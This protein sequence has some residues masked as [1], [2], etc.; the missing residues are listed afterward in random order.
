MDDWKMKTHRTVRFLLLIFLLAAAF[1]I[2]TVF[3]LPLFRNPT[4]KK[5]PTKSSLNHPVKPTPVLW[6][7]PVSATVN[8]PTALPCG[9]LVTD[10]HGLIL[11]LTETGDIRWQASY[12]NHVWQA[13]SV[14]DNETICA[15]TRKGKLVLFETITGVIKWSVE[16]EVSCLHPP[17]VEMLNQQRVIIL[18]SQDDG[19]LVCVN[20]HDG[21]FRWRSPATSRSD[22]PPIRVGDFIAYGNCDAAV[23]LFS[24][25][26]G[27]LKGSIQLAEDEQ[28]A[29]GV[30]RLTDGRLIVGTRSGKLAMLD[31]LRMRCV[32]RVTVSDSE[33]F[34]TPV[35]IGTNRIFM[36]VSE[37]RMTFWK[38]EGD[39]L[40]ADTGV[41]LASQFD[42]TCVV[43]NIFWAI[44][45]HSVY[46]VRTTDP[47]H[48]IQ[49]ELGDNLHG[50]APSCFGKT[51][52]IAD[53][54]LV[55]VKG[56]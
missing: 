13:S 56:F 55:C 3:H 19:T 51:V 24:I 35:Q 7:I 11:S 27:C 52:V 18:L 53:G 46:G 26:N 4:E 25:T 31:T 2:Y 41:Q 40:I 33:A 45:Q 22:G 1:A 12:S 15:I 49:Y 48:R 37:G 36:P 6:C 28:V 10:T 9:W 17:L 42:E 21:S 5:I 39:R 16:T 20:A 43:D 32:S 47:S 23:H 50:I 44:A 8:K 14:V 34:A 54:E 38:I 29:G 30:L